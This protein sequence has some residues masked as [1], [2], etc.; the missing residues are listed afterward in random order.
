MSGFIKYFESGAN[1]MSFM[2]ED[3]DIY[4]KY[5]E[6]WDK[7]KKHL[8]LKFSANPIRDKNI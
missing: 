2:T 5:S 1:N 6:I 8:K 3:K 7:I 4:L